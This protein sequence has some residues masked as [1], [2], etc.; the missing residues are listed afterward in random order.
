L[1]IIEALAHDLPI[2]TTRWRAI[3]GMLPRKYAWVVDPERPDQ[4]ADALAAARDAGPPAGACRR[5][6]EKRFTAGA[7]LRAMAVELRPIVTS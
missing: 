5:E 2:V 6:Y 4:I 3:P 7:H 1:T